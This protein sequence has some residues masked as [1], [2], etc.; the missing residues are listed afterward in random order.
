MADLGYRPLKGRLIL[1]DGA[2]WVCT[3]STGD[4]WP[5]GTTVWAKVG[6]LPQWDAQV[7][8]ETGTATFV[9]QAATTDTVAD[10]TPYII[11]LRHPGSPTTE[12]AWFQDK[13]SR[14]K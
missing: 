6:N 11:Y 9:V 2:D 10:N 1:T 5:E 14:T 8:E 12:F 3:L 13:V 7:V 4:V